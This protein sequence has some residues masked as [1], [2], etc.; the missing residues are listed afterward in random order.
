V[1]IGQ[2][3]NLTTPLQLAF[4]TAILANNGRIFRPHVVR[5]IEDSQT[6]A[7]ITIE[8]QPIGLVPLKEQNLRRIRDA[9][10]D[11]TR[12][13]GTAA[14][15]GLNAKYAFAGKTGTSQVFS[16]KGQ[17]YD[18]E[19]VHERLRD[20]ALFIAFAPADDPRIALAVLVEN[21]GH[22]SS[23]AAPIARKVIDYYLLGIEPQ[24]V[25]P[26][27]RQQESEGD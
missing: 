24:P 4:A 23:T 17:A 3:Y 22:G 26:P 6:N 21:G 11:V 19:R 15:S 12:P 27:T 7:L 9:M 1:G 16:M 14:W 20:H 13:G 5:H 8:P 18:E 2:G 25:Q 10:I